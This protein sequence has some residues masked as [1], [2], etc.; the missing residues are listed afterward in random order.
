M[1][2]LRARSS[3]SEPVLDPTTLI[4]GVIEELITN[5][6]LSR[7]E[8][9]TKNDMLAYFELI[10]EIVFNKD[11]QVIRV[12]RDEI[13]DV[14]TRAADAD[15]DTILTV[16]EFR[17]FLYTE[18]IKI[19]QRNY[20]QTAHLQG[21]RVRVV[22]PAPMVPGGGSFNKSIIRRKNKSKITKKVNHRKNKSKITKKLNH[23]KIKSQ[24][25]YRK[26]TNR[27][28]KHKSFFTKTLKKKM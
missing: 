8:N 5:I 21:L 22:D 15:K 6:N 11:S 3:T 20:D 27:L 16:D 23:R 17:E 28:R 4:Q 12:N 25:S 1:R 18:A 10:G 19:I 24:K 2:K 9:I 13:T 7:G 26:H 14:I